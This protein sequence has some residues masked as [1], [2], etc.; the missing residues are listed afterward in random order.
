MAAPDFGQDLELADA[1]AAHFPVATGHRNLLRAVFRR[2]TTSPTDECGEI[3]AGECLDVR[4]L[5]AA[6]LD[7]Q[8]LQSIAR[9][10]ERTCGYDERIES[11]TCKAT[12]DSPQKKLTLAVNLTPS[13]G[14]TFPLV[15]LTD[16]LTVEILNG[17]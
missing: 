8:R 6:R 15:L 16:G 5:F 3:Y 17:D 12:M 7:P 2:L 1:F 9:S 10:I 11:A 14:P 13:A 4:E